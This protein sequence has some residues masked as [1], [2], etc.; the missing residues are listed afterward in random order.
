[1]CDEAKVDDDDRPYQSREWVGAIEQKFRQL[2]ADGKTPDE[3]AALVAVALFNPRNTAKQRRGRWRSLWYRLLNYRRYS[4]HRLVA[5]V[6]FGMLHAWYRTSGSLE[7]S[8][9]RGSKGPSMVL[10]GWNYYVGIFTVA[11]I[12]IERLVIRYLR[13]PRSMVE[14]VALGATLLLFLAI[15]FEWVGSVLLWIESLGSRSAWAGWLDV[16]AGTDYL[17]G[18]IVEALLFFVVL[19]LMFVEIFNW[20]EQRRERKALRRVEN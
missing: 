15:A 16:V 4:A 14:G 7:I 18:Y 6:A 20:P 8:I 19:R 11:I 10:F 5:P 3:D 1:M 9:I 2:I 13:A 17:I 12:A